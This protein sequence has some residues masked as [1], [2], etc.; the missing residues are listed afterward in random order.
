MCCGRVGGR[1]F[2]GTGMSKILLTG[3]WRSCELWGILDG[4]G[5]DSGDLGHGSTI[6]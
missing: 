1:I 2:N 5:D 4:R 3:A 6:E